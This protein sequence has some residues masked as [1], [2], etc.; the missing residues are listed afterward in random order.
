MKKWML[1]ALVL[2]CSSSAYAET[3][4][5]CATK[6]GKQINLDYNINKDIATY[7]FGKNLSKP[8][9]RLQRAGG[10]LDAMELRAGET[11]AMN[12]GAYTY[13]I[14]NYWGPPHSAGVT[15]SKSGKQLADVKCKGKV[16][17]AFDRLF[18]FI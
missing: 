10:Q 5:H 7:S 3:I 1:T 2:A 13:E 12:N 6:S 15:V 9:I 17:T 11:V 8:E 14:Y 16:Y 18:S 4:F